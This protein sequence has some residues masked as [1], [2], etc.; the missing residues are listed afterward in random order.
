MEFH[1]SRLRPSQT[2]IY[3]DPA[4]TGERIGATSLWKRWSVVSKVPFLG[5]DHQLLAR[6]TAAPK[7][8]INVPFARVQL[9]AEMPLDP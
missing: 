9:V 8:W 3:R 1:R 7:E 6:R 5:E 4:A 2:E